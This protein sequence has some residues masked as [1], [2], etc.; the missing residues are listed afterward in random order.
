MRKMNII[1]VKEL[2]RRFKYH[3]SG[4]LIR[5]I[6]SGQRGP[7]GSIL[8]GCI[9]P[10]G[11]RITTIRGKHFKMHR[12]IF[13][14]KKG[15]WPIRT[16]H[17]DR[18][19]QNNKIENLRAASHSQNVMNSKLRSDNKTKTRGLHFN[20]KDGVWIGLV[21]VKRKNSYVCS[22][23]KNLVIQK[24]NALRKQKFGKFHPKEGK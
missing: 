12:L 2:R 5:K 22:K 19:R 15:W 21:T 18:N 4:Y 14:I 3:P 24:L 17:K 23:N 10:E 6:T 16:D 8:K 7:E 11:Y 9:S 20:K 13:A 1:P